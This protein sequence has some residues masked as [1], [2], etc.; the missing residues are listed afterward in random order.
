[1]KKALK[2]ITVRIYYY[3]DGEK[4]EAVPAGIRGNLS[5]CEITDEEREKGIDVN[6][7]NRMN[8]LKWDKNMRMWSIDIRARRHDRIIKNVLERLVPWYCAFKEAVAVSIFIVFFVGA[9]LTFLLN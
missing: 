5:D 4:I 8:T 3:K 6:D 7:L 9:S 1:M 2:K